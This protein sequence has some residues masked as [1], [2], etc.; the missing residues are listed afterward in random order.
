MPAN[1]WTRDLSHE[2]IGAGEAQRLDLGT[3]SRLRLQGEKGMSETVKLEVLKLD[4][5]FG[6]TRKNGCDRHRVCINP[7]D[8]VEPICRYLI[9]VDKL[10]QAIEKHGSEKIL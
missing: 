1:E 9:G 4:L 2:T 5:S 6:C 7:T 3:K 10:K 8:M